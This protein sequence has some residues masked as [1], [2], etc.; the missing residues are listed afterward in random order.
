MTKQKNNTKK[1]RVFIRNL[2][3]NITEEK[4]KE[5]FSKFGEINEVHLPKKETGELKGFGFIQFVE[6]KDALKAIKEMD[7]FKFDGRKITLKLALTKDD[8]QEEKEN[9]KKLEKE[10]SKN[11]GKNENKIIPIE[12]NNNKPLLNDPERTIFIR[13]LGFNTDEEG[14]K[15]FFENLQGNV[16][17]A[18][19]VKDPQTK[20]SKGTGFVMFRTS[21]DSE[22]VL[23]LFRKYQYDEDRAA[24]NPFELDGRNLKVFPAMAK[25]DAEKME[26]DGKN[27]NED[28][29]NRHL[30][31]YGLSA[32]NIKFFPSENQNISSE[33]KER[34][35]ALIKIKKSNFNKN[36]NYHVSDTRISLRNFEKNVDENK[37]KEIFTKKA[38]E[39]IA[40]LPI[41]EKKKFKNVKKIKQ[42]KLLKN[43]N[44]TDREGN[45]KS[46][47]IAFVE[48][49]DVSLAKGLINLLSNTKI[50]R[51]SKKGLIIDFALDDA[52]KIKQRTNKQKRKKEKNSDSNEDNENLSKKEEKIQAKEKIN[53]I[54]DIDKLKEL[55]IFSKS[56]GKKQ[57]IKKKL[58]T[59]G[60]NQP[61]L[62]TNA[63]TNLKKKEVIKV[64]KDNFVTTKVENSNVNLNQKYQETNKNKKEKMLERKR[65][66]D[67]AV[68]KKN[69][70]TKNNYTNDK[71]NKSDQ[72]NSK[73]E[74]SNIT[75][76]FSDEDDDMNPMYQ[77][78]MTNLNKARKANKK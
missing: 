31:Y 4:I 72:K 67:E 76:D 32:S 40:S 26:K 73:N 33:D 46:K 11:I 28:K 78:I 63:N 6:K 24:L 69:K 41:E 17:Y 61:I 48:T 59:L 14:L 9:I 55:Y 71:K 50:N 60:F 29:R 34:R 30:L 52:R 35:E 42:I 70:P 36:P 47:C 57:R 49:C 65:H 44:E 1:G 20:V 2:P 21:E 5:T 38:E 16:L 54:T 22:Q 68:V 77:Q 3:F 51:N 53:E 45:P 66:R 18:K 7:N 12:K 75:E 15:N 8:Y 37:L 27:K 10:K 62:L 13:N 56:R 64:K 43:K 74:K 25:E 19:V 23:S 58:K 39:F